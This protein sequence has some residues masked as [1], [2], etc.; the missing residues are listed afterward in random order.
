MVGKKKLKDDEIIK[1]KSNLTIISNKINSNQRI[2]IKF[3]I[4]K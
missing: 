4:K 3:S 2:G 1:K